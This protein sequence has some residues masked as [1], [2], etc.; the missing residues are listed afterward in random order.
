MYSI[1][2]INY[3]V[4]S[5][6]ILLI[7]PRDTAVYLKYNRQATR[8]LSVLGVFERICTIP[9]LGVPAAMN[10][11]INISILTKFANTDL[12]WPCPYI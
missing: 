6:V 10:S 7:E 12:Y 2:P 4:C 1:G 11:T 3:L 8:T 9:N 5:P